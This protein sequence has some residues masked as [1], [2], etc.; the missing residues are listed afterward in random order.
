MNGILCGVVLNEDDAASRGEGER[1]RGKRG[2]EGLEG[3]GEEGEVW[4]DG[5]AR[6]G[7]GEGCKDE[8]YMCSVW[9]RD[10][11]KID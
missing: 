6:R 9:C 1:L 11:W 5:V 4:R 8:L 7:L 10:S 3:F 2:E